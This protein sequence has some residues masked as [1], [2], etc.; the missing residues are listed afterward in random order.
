[1][2]IAATTHCDEVGRSVIPPTLTR[3]LQQL[4][5]DHPQ[6]GKHRGDLELMQFLG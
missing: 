5:S 6:L 3:C 1:M 2:R 4:P